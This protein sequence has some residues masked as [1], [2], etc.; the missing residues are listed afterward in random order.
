MTGRVS[1]APDGAGV[2]VPV[3]AVDEESGA[4]MTGTTNGKGPG[5]CDDRPS[6]STTNTSIVPPAGTYH[7]IEPATL[8]EKARAQLAAK[9]A[10]AGGHVLTE[11]SDGSFIV[12]RWG[13]TRHCN[14]LYA[15]AQFAR[16]LGVRT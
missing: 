5:A 9:L 7:Q 13:Q 15:V 10:L 12:S 11:L 16:L 3:S 4:L 8:A 14:D 1:D 6:E 2:S